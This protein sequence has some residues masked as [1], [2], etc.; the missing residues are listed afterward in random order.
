MPGS[1]NCFALSQG[2]SPGTAELTPLRIREAQ[3]PPVCGWCRAC[4]KCVPAEQEGTWPPS[5]VP[6][7]PHQCP[8]AEQGQPWAAGAAPKGLQGLS[9][10]LWGCVSLLWKWQLRHSTHRCLVAHSCIQGSPRQTSPLHPASSHRE[11]SS[12]S[13]QAAGSA[14][15]HCSSCLPNDF[16]MAWI[17][18]SLHPL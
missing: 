13:A 5:R 8:G 6:R 9:S 7:P 17:C 12:G 14:A 16:D 11:E 4:E 10:P 1:Y 3:L 18:I 15:L 2:M